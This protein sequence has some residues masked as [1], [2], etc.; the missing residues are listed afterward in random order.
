VQSESSEQS[1]SPFDG[2][3]QYLSAS[4]RSTRSQAWPFVESHVE[5]LVHVIGHAEAWLQAF[6]AAP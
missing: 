5:S 6:P 1:W 3:V 2:V 4:E